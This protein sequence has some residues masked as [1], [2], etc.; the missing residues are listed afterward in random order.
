MAPRAIAAGRRGGLFRWADCF[1]ARIEGDG[2]A[3][4]S[5]ER[6]LHVLSLVEAIEALS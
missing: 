3:Y 6:I 2:G 5:D 1:L 4:V